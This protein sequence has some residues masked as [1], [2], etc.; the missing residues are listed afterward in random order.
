MR[1]RELK[2]NLEVY[3][4]AA[5][6]SHEDGALVQRAKEATAN[7]YAPYSH[8]QVGAAVLLENG[9][10]ITGSNQE[11]GAYP[12][13]TCAERTALF[14]AGAKYPNVSVKAIA[15]AAQSGGKFCS[16]SVYPCGACRQVMLESQLRSG[17]PIRVIMAGEGEVE[18][19]GSVHDLLPLS[20][21][22][23]EAKK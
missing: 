7:A 22:L 19:V 21:D 15:I 6:M 2:I 9:E 16:Q 23:D 10:V 4:S 1:N 17:Q 8:F 12:S 14:Y 11:N 18:V 3:D 13:G 20:F 5:E